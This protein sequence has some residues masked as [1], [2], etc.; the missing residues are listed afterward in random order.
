MLYN[1]S[2]KIINLMTKIKTVIR[3]S[4]SN[5]RVMKSRLV[6]LFAYI[7]HITETKMPTHL[8]G[9]SENGVRM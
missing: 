3:I 8:Y 4:P 7:G 5:I 6:G 1:I 9:E 2:D